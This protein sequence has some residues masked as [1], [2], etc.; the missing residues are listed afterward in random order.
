MNS[1]ALIICLF[2]TGKN[3]ASGNSDWLVTS[4]TYQPHWLVIKKVN[5]EPCSH[6]TT[7]SQDTTDCLLQKHQTYRHH[8]PLHPDQLLPQHLPL[9]TWWLTIITVSPLPSRPWLPW[10]PTQSHLLTLLPG[11]TFTYA[12][13]KPST[14]ATEQKA[15]SLYTS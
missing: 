11:F 5:L 4:E 15:D 12:S 9:L 10:K 1:V 8:R 3:V 2:C 13:S 7:Q 6:P 14:W